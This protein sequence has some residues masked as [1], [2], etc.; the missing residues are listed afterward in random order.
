MPGSQ[1]L[2]SH[3]VCST[4]ARLGGTS[5][6]EESA[7]AIPVMIFMSYQEPSDRGQSGA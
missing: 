4:G 1:V 5:A 3:S 7:I 2:L 6:H